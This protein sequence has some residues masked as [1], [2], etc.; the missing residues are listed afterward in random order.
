MLI[1]DWLHRAA[2]R[3]PA[4]IALEDA[5]NGRKLTYADLNRRASCFATL[6]VEEFKLHPGDRV[7]ILSHNRPEYLEVLYGCAKS[8]TVLV[9]LNWRLAVGELSSI[10]DDCS[11]SVLVYES[12]FGVAANAIA[13]IHPNCALLVIDEHGGYEDM[14]SAAAPA[15]NEMSPRSTDD[16]WHLLY[17]SGTTG[18]PKGVIQTFGMVFVNAINALLAGKVCSGD[19][20]LNV[21]PFFHTGGLNLYTNP[22]LMVGGTVVIA[23]RFDA[24][25]AIARLSKDITSLFAVPTI[26]LT[27]ASHPD[28]EA[29]DFGAVRNFSVGGAPVPPRLAKIFARK[30]AVIAPGYG[31]TEAGPTIFAADL[32]TAS[33]KPL[34]VGKPVGLAR[35]RIVGESGMEVI[36]SQPGELFIGGPVVTP[37]YWNKPDATTNTI[38]DGWLKTGDVAYR[39]ADG[40]VFI[41]GRKKDMYISGG[42]NVYPVEIENVLQG[43]PGVAEAAVVG[44]PSEKWGEV[45]LA[46]LVAAKGCRI[47]EDDVLSAC[48]SQ[49]A[50]Y[51]VPHFVQVVDALPRTPT[52]KVEK[53][54][55]AGLASSNNV[56][57][58]GV[59]E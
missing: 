11:P 13:A 15:S 17:T 57:A 40:D 12:Q 24:A 5:F 31:M 29:A 10:M 55:L 27:L 53:H 6:L 18:R 33:V 43:V 34:S 25:A 56:E 28:F 45:G 41:V 2:E 36:G 30:G 1:T 52:G 37:G 20:F 49:L 47:A 9:C 35:T 7:A 19:I 32:E 39:D 8:N 26:Y 42:E 50:G 3:H 22:V 58:I 23:R 44:V 46:V 38:C 54:K 59:Q 14:L 4:R 21:L 51:K 16:A 48:R